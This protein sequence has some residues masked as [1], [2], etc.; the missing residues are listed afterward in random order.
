MVHGDI[1][2]YEV[3]T[4][5]SLDEVMRRFDAAW[6]T[7]IGDNPALAAKALENCKNARRSRFRDGETAEIVAPS[8]TQ[9][10]LGEGTAYIS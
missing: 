4:S 2:I 9:H 3:K 10:G 5:A 1:P 8:V 6:A 7:T